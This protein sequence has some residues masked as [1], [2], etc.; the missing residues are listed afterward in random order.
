[1][2][3]NTRKIIIT[4]LFMALT[5]V[6]TM[7][8]RIPSPTGGYANLGDCV[9]LLG[10]FMLSPA[11]A[12]AAGGIGS[13]LADLI[14]GY[15]QYIIGT[16][17]IKALVAGAAALLYRGFAKSKPGVRQVISAAA[18]ELIMVFGYF[19]YDAL[20]LGSGWGAAGGILSNCGQALVG[21]AAATIL[22]LVF[23]RNKVLTGEL[24]A[25]D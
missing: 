7:V 21:V 11:Y 5:C 18:A 17:L 1:M 2:K 20:L 23:K 19:A 24:E 25:E 8:I 4:A 15:P 22:L 14:S 12:V 10:A 3:T 16:L 9:V 6:A 13:A